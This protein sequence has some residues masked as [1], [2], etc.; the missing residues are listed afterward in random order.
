MTKTPWHELPREVRDAVQRELGDVAG[1][2]AIS[3]GLN[4]DITLTAETRSGRLF[5]KGARLDDNLKARQL[6][7]EVSINPYVT[8]LSPKIR[9]QIERAGWLIVGFDHIEGRRADYSPLS[10][11]IPLVLDLLGRLSE[12]PCP[13]IP[14][15]PVDRSAY[16]RPEDLHRF[17]GEALAHA[18]LNPD[19]VRITADRRAYLVDWAR[20]VRS[21]PWSDAA[22]FAMCLMTC[23]HTPRDA[24]HILSTLP[25]WKALEPGDL[26]AVAYYQSAMRSTWK[27]RLDPWTNASVAAA[28][29]WFD[30]RMGLEQA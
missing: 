6:R 26:D 14:L 19:N 3:E 2:E 4:S 16:A 21:A 9:L 12:T 23:G 7:R 27:P 28:R 30:Y 18:D 24:E 17:S 10:P 29:R 20:Y 11:D 8:H 13:D 5:I 15:R 1:I 22:A 25:V